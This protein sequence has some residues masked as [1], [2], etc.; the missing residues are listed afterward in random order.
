MYLVREQNN[1][2]LLFLGDEKPFKHNGSWK[3]KHSCQTVMLDSRLHPEVQWIDREPTKCDIVA[4]GGDEK[5]ETPKFEQFVVRPSSKVEC[6]RLSGDELGDM[7]RPLI[8]GYF[9]RNCEYN[10]QT[11]NDEETGNTLVKCS[12]EAQ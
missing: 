5:P 10:L 2:L 9:C 3:T 4:V 6:P 11:N 1:D 8:G 7:N 12:K